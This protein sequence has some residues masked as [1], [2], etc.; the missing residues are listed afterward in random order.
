MG[1][2][3]MEKLHFV[4][5]EVIAFLEDKIQSGEANQDENKLYEDALLNRQMHKMNHTYKK[6]VME[7]RKLFECKF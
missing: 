1:G 5:E 2:D 6:L 3:N 4:E 7:M